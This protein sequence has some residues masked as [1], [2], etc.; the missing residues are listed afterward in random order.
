MKKLSQL[1]FFS[2][3]RLDPGLTVLRG[4]MIQHANAPRL[5]LAKLDLKVRPDWLAMKLGKN[6]KR[7][8][9]LM[10]LVTEKEN[11]KYQ[12]DKH[13]WLKAFQKLWS[14]IS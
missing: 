1:N 5:L 2:F 3:C 4:R 8:T 12:T 10:H 14:S 7:C 11:K 9:F 13:N 6:G